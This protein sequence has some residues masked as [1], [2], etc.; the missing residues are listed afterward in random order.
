VE[1]NTPNTFVEVGILFNML[2]SSKINHLNLTLRRRKY[3][4]N[5]INKKRIFMN[6]SFN[7]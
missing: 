7:Q 2:L 3:T 4:M 1:K 6:L 5:P